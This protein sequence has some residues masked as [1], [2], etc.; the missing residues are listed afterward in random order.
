MITSL[1][2]KIMEN[3]RQSQISRT[4]ENIGLKFLWVEL[5]LFKVK[6]SAQLIKLNYIELSG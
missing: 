4:L 2:L 5:T 3:T 1:H 6:M